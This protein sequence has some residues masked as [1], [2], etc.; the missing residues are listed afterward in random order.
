MAGKDTPKLLSCRRLGF[1]Q[2]RFELCGLLLF[3]TR[4]DSATP[5]V[6]AQTAASSAPVG[7]LTY[8]GKKQTCARWGPKQTWARWGNILAPDSGATTYLHQMG[9]TLI[10]QLN[11]Y[12]YLNE[13]IT[14][15]DKL[16]FQ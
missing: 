11:K 7:K 6:E 2:R 5:L 4:L 8:G 16:L 3:L 9:T 1:N 13:L 14:V 10:T 12:V 15:C